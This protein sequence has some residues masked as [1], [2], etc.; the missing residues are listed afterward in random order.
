VPSP[1]DEAALLEVAAAS[2]THPLPRDRPL[3]SVTVVNGLTGGRSALVLVI[4]P[5]L[6]DGIG[7]L[8]ALALLIDGALLAS[9]V[10]FPTPPPTTENF[11]S[12]RPPRD[13][14]PSAGGP[15]ASD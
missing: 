1:G 9:E 11:S 7:G 13:F 12:T 15:P 8:A 10:P 14:A 2:A 3:W 6:A 5:V 4:H